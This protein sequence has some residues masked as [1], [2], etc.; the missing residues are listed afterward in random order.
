MNLHRNSALVVF[1]GGQDST[2]CLGWAL[3]NFEKVRCLTFNYGQKH[4]HEIQA[5]V[6][7]IEFFQTKLGQ[8]IPHE[9]VEI[10]PIFAGMSPLTNPEAELETYANHAEMEK[11]I[12]DRVEK[13]FVPMRNAVFLM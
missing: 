2:T 4:D 11:I 9:I 12:G 10:G 5:A 13:T 1:S 8:E 3:A 6:D 7:V